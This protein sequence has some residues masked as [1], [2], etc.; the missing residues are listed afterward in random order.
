VVVIFLAV[1]QNSEAAP[2]L[3]AAEASMI[4]VAKGEAVLAAGASEEDP[5]ELV[6]V[7][8]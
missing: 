8:L 3:A 4:Q 5:E 6:F 7:Q 1:T 2:A